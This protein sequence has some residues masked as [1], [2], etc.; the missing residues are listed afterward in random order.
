MAI[1]SPLELPRPAF[2][3]NELPY[4]LNF[5]Y[6]ESGGQTP[7]G[8]HEPRLDKVQLSTLWTTPFNHTEGGWGDM[9]R[10]GDAGGS[11]EAPCL[12]SV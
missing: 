12:L 6:R 2:I 11:W 8:L 5:A 3:A 9:H 1:R 4:Y 7:V 10:S